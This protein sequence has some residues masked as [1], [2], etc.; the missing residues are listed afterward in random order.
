MYLDLKDALK[1]GER[2]QTPFTPAVGTLIQIHERLAEI[3]AQG[4]AHTEVARIAGLAR[5][6]RNAIRDLPFD[7]ATD[8]PCASVTALRPQTA[9]AYDIFTT[10]KDEYEIWVCPNGGALRDTLF[11]VGHIG[12]LTTD[13]YDVLL[14]ALRDMRRR[15]LI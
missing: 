1:N 8:S 2:G 13:D 4:G 3:A 15:A 10:L 11:R 7:F 14:D 6:F 12:A 9:S 5:Y